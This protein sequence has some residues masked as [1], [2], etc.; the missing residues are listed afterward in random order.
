[1]ILDNLK[2]KIIEVVNESN[3]PVDA[4]Y[5]VMK[6]IM[7]EIVEQYNITLQQEQSAA[8]A[9]QESQTE[10]Q[11]SEPAAANQEEIEKKEEE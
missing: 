8:T 5:F 6:D 1:M 7:S 4:I 11:G 3:L 2:N 9:A 10:V